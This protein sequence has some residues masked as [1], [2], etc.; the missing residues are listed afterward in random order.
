MNLQRASLIVVTAIVL[1]LTWF[2]VRLSPSDGSKNNEL[3]IAALTGDLQTLANS[4]QTLPLVMDSFNNTLAHVKIHAFNYHPHPHPHPHHFLVRQWAAKGGSVSSMRYVISEGVNVLQ[5]NAANS[6]PLHWAVYSDS[7]PIMDLL[8]ESGADPN[9]R[10]SKGETVCHHHRSR[11]YPSQ[12]YPC[13][14]HHHHIS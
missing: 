8:F 9:H 6:P 10:N 4:N 11:H 13:H 1:V 3:Y 12:T 7:E 5:P 14:R 2:D